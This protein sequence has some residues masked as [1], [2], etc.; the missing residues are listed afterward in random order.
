[1]NKYLIEILKIQSSVILPSFG[2]LMVSNSK[3]G[4]VVF[5][6]HLKFNDGA[7]AKFIAE[8]EGTDE[9][10]AQNQIAKFVRE[11]EAELGKGNSYD[12]FE[13][14]SFSKDKDGN[15]EFKMDAK[16][17]ITGDGAAASKAPASA[18]KTET[19][20]PTKEKPKA[21]E[22]T[23][24][25]PVVDK[26]AEKAAAKAKAAEEKAAAKAK[27]VADKA[28]AKAKVEA[29][30]A[31][32][33]AK[34]EADKA[35][36]KAKIEADKLAAKTKAEADKKA[37]ATKVAKADPIKKEA[38]KAEAKAKE[39]EVKQDKNKF[40]PAADKTAAA[41]KATDGK[42][43]AIERAVGDASK[44]A[45][46]KKPEIKTGSKTETPQE[47]NKFTPAD[48]KKD[49]GTSKAASAALT[50]AGKTA[51]STSD[52]VE[53]SKATGDKGM[54]SIKDKYK[55]SG[56]TDKKQKPS[57]KPK[58]EKKKKEEGEK[59][60]KNRWPLII[61]LILLIGGGGTA[62][63]IYKDKIM[64]MFNGTE[65]ADNHEGEE[66]G[67]GDGHGEG[68]SNENATGDGEGNGD[69]SGEGNGDGTGDGT[70]GSID[71]EEIVTDEVIEE[72]VEEEIVEEQPV[73]N[74]TSTGGN[75][76]VIGNAFSES[77]NA[78]KY[79]S[80]MQGKGYGSAKVLGRFDN[81]Y[82]VSIQQFDSQS[83]ASSGASSAGDG[84]WVF[85]YPK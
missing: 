31:A 24:A 9:Q 80:D 2:S 20:A 34:I 25:A 3:T 78:D 18:K 79:V 10:A 22:K 66:N 13:F 84:A 15:V 73:V 21:E 72:V 45:E 47:K 5:N 70:E 39:P 41:K 28:A 1:M 82:M 50:A 51:Q 27:A 65:V 62:G 53:D 54:A 58:K 81:L 12:M 23:A 52:K 75:Y 55:K 4:K 42:K 33:K 16:G 76:H 17:A 43:T 77:S 68:E 14:G 38:P 37:A 71:G 8:K 67:E 49:A 32:A 35:A 83:A 85:K 30:K 60:K 63:Y 19:K 44:A 36:A 40:V 26:K 74:N 11:I 57:A 46:I 56:A 6:P 48:E 7:L 64:A 29:D 69:G 59:K 61:I